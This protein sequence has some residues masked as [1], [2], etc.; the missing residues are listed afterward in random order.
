M[1]P[2]PKLP[3]GTLEQADRILLLERRAKRLASQNDEQSKLILS[4]QLALADAQARILEQAKTLCQHADS[5]EGVG[6]RRPV[7]D[8]VQEVLV[9]Y[10]GVTWE[11]IT[12]V[13]REKRLIEPRHR[14]MA[15]VYEERKDLSLPMLG[16]VFRRDHTTIL[17]AVHKTEAKR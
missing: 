10:P 8:I 16:R 7:R 5:S 4:L 15:A 9:L 13:R 3:P 6:V 17:H 1:N 11:D 12:S 2:Q 14:C